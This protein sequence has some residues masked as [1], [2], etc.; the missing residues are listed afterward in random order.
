MEK[1]SNRTY[2][3]YTSSVLEILASNTPKES[4]EEG[5]MMARI[6]AKL[7]SGKKLTPK[8]MDYLRAHNPRL[9]AQAL[10]IEI[11]RRD[12]EEQCKHA[13]SKKQINDIQFTALSSVSKN[14]P[15][16]Q[17]IQ[18]AI[19]YAIKEFKDSDAYKLLPDENDEEKEKQLHSAIQDKECQ[20][21]LHEIGNEYSFIIKANKGCLQIEKIAVGISD[22]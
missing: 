3:E 15:Y 5:R 1:I 8:E 11:I 7:Q 22:Y 13:T 21:K 14:D 20:E 12:V 18:A 6:M 9:Y 2:H 10:R 16:R 17:Y 4:E 19:Q